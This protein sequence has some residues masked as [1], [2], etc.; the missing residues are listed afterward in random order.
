MRTATLATLILAMST[1]MAAAQDAIKFGY[2]QTPAG[3]LAVVADKTELWAKSGLKLESISFAAAINARDAI[4]G[5]RLDVSIA[6]LT[7]FLAGASEAGIVSLGVAVDQCASAAILVKPGSTV[8]SVADLKGK[9]IASQSGT[10]TQSVLVNRLLPGAKL[11]AGGVQL[12][13]LRFQDMVSALSARSVDAAA[14][15]DPSCHRPN[16]AVQ[17]VAIERPCREAVSS[18]LSLLSVRRVPWRACKLGPA[19][20]STAA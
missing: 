8:R 9:R 1:A 5:G 13:N 11:T 3:A 20:H 10:I 19:A 4:I 15:V 17:A 2:P 12:V 6:G 18:V 7:N 16:R 14:A